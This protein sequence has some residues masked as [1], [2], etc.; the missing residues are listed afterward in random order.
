IQIA[1]LPRDFMVPP[2]PLSLI[3]SSNTESDCMNEFDSL[4]YR[5]YPAALAVLK[6]SAANEK[7]M[8]SF[9]AAI[10]PGIRCS[11]PYGSDSASRAESRADQ[12]WVS[13]QSPG[14]L[15]SGKPRA[16][17]WDGPRPRRTA[18]RGAH[19]GIAFARRSRL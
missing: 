3:N 2:L 19:Q 10:V 5:R 18:A 1:H 8:D 12:R 17:G 11:L 7:T 6:R 4:M 16:W 14:E 13:G 15:A 9:S